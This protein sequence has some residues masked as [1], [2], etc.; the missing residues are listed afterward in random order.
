MT[1]FDIEQYDEPELIGG[2]PIWSPSIR[3]SDFGQ[4]PLPDTEC[5]ADKLLFAGSVTLLAGAPKAG[6][7]TFLFHLVNAVSRGEKFLGKETRQANILYATEQSE[8]SFRAQTVKVP[9]FFENPKTFVVLVEHNCTWVPVIHPVTK[10]HI[11]DELTGEK[12][13]KIDFFDTWEKQI[14]FW[15][16]MVIKT[17][18]KVLVVDTFTSFARLKENANN[19][20]GVIATR[21]M[22]LK[23]LFS[24]RPDLAILVIHHLRKPENNPKHQRS[25]DENDVLGSQS[26]IAGVDQIVVLAETDRTYPGP[27]RTLSF[28]GRF[29]A[30]SS[31]NVILTEN[32]YVRAGV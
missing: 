2:A 25:Q 16:E 32:S 12:A 29:E 27:M 19:D 6:K 11:E 13:Y 31:T 15:R 30:E 4:R 14:E 3:M 26:Y 5:Y 8:A 20:P 21:L 10:E 24:T 22:E 17:H 7:S 18:A 23:G 28:K 9:G 1:Q